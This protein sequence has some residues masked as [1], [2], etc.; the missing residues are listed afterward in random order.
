QIPNCAGYQAFLA[1]RVPALAHEGATNDAAKAADTLKAYLA[2]ELIRSTVTKFL[3][4][5]ALCMAALASPGAGAFTLSDGTH[6]DCVAGGRIVPEQ[7]ATGEEALAG[8][9]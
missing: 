9:T 1:N 6:V 2:H 7:A 3:I 5:V 8:F 4:A